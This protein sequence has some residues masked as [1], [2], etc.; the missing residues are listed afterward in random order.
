[1]AESSRWLNDYTA[2]LFDHGLPWC[3]GAQELLEELSAEG[4]PMALVTNTQRALTERAL[5]GI[6]REYFSATVCGD[7]V[8]QRQTRS[9]PVPAGSRVAGIW[10]RS[11]AWPSRTRSREPAAAEARR[12]PGPGGA[13][14]CRGAPREW[15]KPC[16]FA[17]RGGRRPT[18]AHPC[19][20]H[21][22]RR[23]TLG[24]TSP[25][26]VLANGKTGV[27]VTR[28]THATLRKGRPWQ[29]PMPP[30]ETNPHY[31]SPTR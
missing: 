26:S 10:R 4:T 30:S 14:R 13:K 20:P 22:R 28:I 8:R 12:M 11:S 16:E 3:D 21:R 17:G 7:E 18:A 19:R 2:E 29:A 23:R 27:H 6:G 5:N 15:A 1:M 9:G 24:L 31:R 25:R